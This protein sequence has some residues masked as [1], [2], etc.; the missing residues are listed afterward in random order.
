[1]CRRPNQRKVVLMS[2]GGDGVT[3]LAKVLISA[4]LDAKMFPVVMKFS[5]EVVNDLEVS[6]FG[7]AQRNAAMSLAVHS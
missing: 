3:V 2:R 4:S 6:E 1:M 7:S 5:R